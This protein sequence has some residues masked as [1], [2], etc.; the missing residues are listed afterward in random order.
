MIVRF[1]Y[2]S[3]RSNRRRVSFLRH[4]S[5]MSASTFEFEPFRGVN[6]VFSASENDGPRLEYKKR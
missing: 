6:G 5:G 4:R 3:K 1:M 2:V